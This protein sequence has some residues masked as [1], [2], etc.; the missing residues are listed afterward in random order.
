MKNLI[1]K[2]SRQSVITLIIC[3]FLIAGGCYEITSV[4][5]PDVVGI[6][7][8]FD[9]KIKVKLHGG[10]EPNDYS[11]SYG[12]LGILIP[13]GW[14]V[15]DSVEWTTI[16][17]ADVKKGFFRYDNSLTYVLSG[18]TGESPSGYYWWG[19]R[20]VDL[21]DIAYLDSGLI[22]LTILTDG[23]AGIYDIRYVL[24]DET[25]WSKSTHSD[26]FGIVTKSRL[27]SV[28]ADQ[29]QHASEF[30]E[31][32]EIRIYPNPS[33]GKMYINAGNLHGVGLM[34]VY[35]LA[36]RTVGSE[37]LTSGRNSID[38]SDLPKG[39]YIVALENQGCVKTQKIIIQ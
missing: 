9:V 3:L 2:R 24:G 34:R 23:N 37:S 14:I 27:F 1:S 35:D 8:A 4:I 19:A 33:G 7:S 5:C 25:I 13:K 6:N 39:T 18:F 16:Q 29:I 11:P 17:G 15:K 21:I 22:N 36:G 38:L 32:E 30:V 31:N 10:Y 26:P 20:S 28:R 12:Y